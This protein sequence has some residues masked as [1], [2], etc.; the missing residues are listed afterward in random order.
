MTS[1][2]RRNWM[3]SKA[4]RAPAAVVTSLV[5]GAGLVGAGL[6]S[7]A[8]PAGATSA[9]ASPAA[10][11]PAAGLPWKI[12]TAAGGVG[13]PGQ[14]RRIA[15]GGPCSVSFAAGQL[16]LGEEGGPGAVVRKISIRTGWM[17][18]PAGTV[19]VTGPGPDGIAA[20]G[21]GL[22]WVCGLAVDGS[23]NLL[24]SDGG[25]FDDGSPGGGDNQVRVDAA[26]SGTFYG[27]QMR[28]GHLYAIA[29]DGDGGYSGDGGPARQADLS[30]P[31]GLAVG[32]AGN[33]IFADAGNDRVRL[34]AVRSGT[35]TDSR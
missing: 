27:Q 10:A 21:A 28:A 29:G 9:G 25:Y 2:T 35:F 12:E 26:R 1:W 31:A 34:V 19:D 13:G 33:V 8:T 22:N 17:S 24:I 5:V 3:F 4:S 6:L 7:V 20:R 15:T 30:G 14:A 23:G 16:Y 18:T 32:P 11:S